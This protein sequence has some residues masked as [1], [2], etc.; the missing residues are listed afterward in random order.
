MN[1]NLFDWRQLEPFR[2]DAAAV[3]NSP[4]WLSDGCTS[5][6]C[7]V[8]WLLSQCHPCTHTQTNTDPLRGLADPWF[9]LSNH[10]VLQGG[11]AIL[12]ALWKNL[13]FVWDLISVIHRPSPGS[14]GWHWWCQVLPPPSFFYL[15]HTLYPYCYSLAASLSMSS[16][17]SPLSLFVVALKEALTKAKL[18]GVH[19]LTLLW[20][21]LMAA[22]GSDHINMLSVCVCVH[23]LLLRVS[24]SAKRRPGLLN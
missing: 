10:C 13:A 8:T 12:A 19:T 22:P 21:C 5:G 9:P 2:S 20:L 1:R 15:S 3:F 23:V 14:C 24:L 4:Y 6:S 17:L 16:S 7:S 18:V 11:A